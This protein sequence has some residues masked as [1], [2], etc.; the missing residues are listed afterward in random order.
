MTTIEEMLALLEVQESRALTDADRSIIRTAGVA[1]LF[2]H[3]QGE[4]PN[5]EKFLLEFDMPLSRDQR[6]HLKSKVGRGKQN[7]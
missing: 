3:S 6:R 2:I 4:W 7:G 1:L 5:F